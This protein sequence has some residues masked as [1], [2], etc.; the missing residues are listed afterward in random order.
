[1]HEFTSLLKPFHYELVFLF[2]NYNHVLKIGLLHDNPPTTLLNLLSVI[3]YVTS[4]KYENQILYP[5]SKNC[6]SIKAYPFET[7]KHGGENII[8]HFKKISRVENLTQLNSLKNLS[9]HQKKSIPQPC[10]S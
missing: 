10:S 6:L 3:C 7:V 2:I 4:K 5:A 9:I 1:M 8:M